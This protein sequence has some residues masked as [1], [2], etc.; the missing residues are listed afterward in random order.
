M[1][2]TVFKARKEVITAKQ[3]TDYKKPPEGVYKE[4]RMYFLK[5]DGVR[6]TLTDWV[7]KIGEHGPFVFGD[8]MFKNIYVPI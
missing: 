2:N 1:T 6:I 7:V 8:E 3:F 4:G 5:P